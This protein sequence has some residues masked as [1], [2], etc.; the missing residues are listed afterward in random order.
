M[1]G[2]PAMVDVRGGSRGDGSEP[3]SPSRLGCGF[4]GFLCDCNLP[5]SFLRNGLA[6]LLRGRFLR[7]C[8]SSF[9]ALRNG[10]FFDRMPLFDERGEPPRRCAPPGPRLAIGAA[11]LRRHLL[12]PHDAW[13]PRSPGGPAA[14]LA[15]LAA[16][17]RQLPLQVA[18]ALDQHFLDIRAQREQRVYVHVLETNAGHVSS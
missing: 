9:T 10:E 15:G 16:K 4:S 17:Q 11:V 7:G 14:P 1:S 13:P 3:R 2:S 18:T 6:A 8:G 12:T 5:A